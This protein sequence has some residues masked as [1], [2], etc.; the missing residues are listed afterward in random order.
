MKK[1][2]IIWVLGIII[3]LSSMVYQRLTGPTYEKKAEV[4][5]EGKDYSFDLIR[6]AENHEDAKIEL[7]LDGKLEARLYYRKHQN[8]QEVSDEFTKVEFKKVEGKYIAFLPKQP[9]AGKLFYYI[10]IESENNIYRLPEEEG[11]VI[12]FKGF[13]PR[14]ILFPHILFMIFAMLFSN[15]AGLYVIFRKENYRVVMYIALATLI[16]GGMIL[17]PAVQY[18]A[19]GDWWTGIP[20]GWDLTDNKTLFALIF[21][22]IAFATNYKKKRPVWV[23]VAAIVMLL[24]YL[25][26]H[27]MFGSELDYSSGTVTQG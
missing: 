13:T 12:R 14:Y 20:F 6:S 27:S 22:I 3:S 7:E 16:V 26:P 17:G 23:L 5:I 15:V 18:Y 11:V 19:F 10:E 4:N 2:W 9:M 21:W 8:N 1:N 25:I 24:V